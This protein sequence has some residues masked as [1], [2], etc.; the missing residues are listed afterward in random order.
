VL[1]A[2]VRQTAHLASVQNMPRKPATCIPQIPEEHPL[3]ALV[4]GPSQVTFRTWAPWVNTLALEILGSQPDIL[5]MQPHP[6]G[7]WETTVSHIGAG[8]RYQYVLH[9]TLRR[10]DPASRFQPEGVHGPSEVVEPLAFLWTDQQWKG[11]PLTDYIIYELHT[12]TF[13]DKGTFDGIIPFLPYLRDDVGITAIELMPIT[14]FP[15]TR[16]WGYDSTYLFAPHN[17]YGGP[18]GLH[19]FIDACHAADLAVVLDVVYNHLGPEGNYW[20]D[21]GPFFTNQYHTPWG[22]AINYDGPHSDAV[23]D[24][25]IANAVYWIRDYHIDALRLDAIHSI[26]DFSVTHILK[27]IRNAVHVEGKRAGR[28]VSV[29]AE[30]DLNDVKLLLPASKGGYGLDAQ[31]NDDFHHALHA[32]VTGERQGYYSDFGSLDHIATAFRQHF[33]L[34]GHYSQHRHRRH[35]NSA[36]HIVPSKFIVFS[37]NH[38]Q[39]GNRAHGDRLSTLIPFAAQQVLAASV[40]LSPF[41]PLLF[42]GEEYGER[43]PFQ[44]FIDHG[45]KGL[46]EAVRKGRLAEFKPFGWKNI[47]DPYAMATFENS[48]LTRPEDRDDA[49][50]HIAAWTTHLIALR[51]QHASLGTGLKGHQLRIWVNPAKTILTIYRKNPKAEAMLLILGFNDQPTTLTLHQPKGQWTLLLD[52]G[53]LEYAEPNADSSSPAPITIDLTSTKRTISLPAFTAWI[54]KEN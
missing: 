40:L 15:G 34:N 49:Q 52:N 8:T 30:S 51:K 24:T 41:I 18:A 16:N 42:M 44:Y 17:T 43:S 48:K 50:Q 36:M 21:F 11:L 37:Q 27:D 10:P 6:F 28:L 23:R 26:Y 32:L 9:E 1:S 54:Y 14:Q 31:W 4:T 13:T 22:S 2:I 39:I 46:I 35:G 53:R 7:Y 47:P 12:G 19:R 3:G 20:G 25:I 5:P 45:D 29:I 38:D 33:V